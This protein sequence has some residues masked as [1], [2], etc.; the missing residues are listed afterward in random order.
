MREA[1]RIAAFRRLLVSYAGD[2]C[3]DW[4]VSIAAAVLVFAETNSAMATTALFLANR[5][6]PAVVVPPLA[7]RL[8]R[9]RPTRALTWL[10]GTDVLVLVALAYTATDFSLLAVCVLAFADGTLAATGRAI[11]RSATAT[12]MTREGLLREGNAVLN[13]SFGIM[14]VAAPAIAGALVAA[15]SAQAVFVIAAG[16][17][18]GLALLMGITEGPEGTSD[19]AGW[20]TRLRAGASSAL[21]NS[22]VRSV[23]VLEAAL[24]VLFAMATPIEIVLAKDTLGAGDAG[25]GLLLAS[26]GAGMVIGSVAFSRILRQS[27][28]R[29]LVIS[30]VMVGVA[31]VGMGLAPTLIVACAA[32]VFGGAGNG[33]QWVSVV[34]V[35]QEAVEDDMQTR[36]AGILEAVGTAMP[37]LGFLLGG[38]LASAFDPRV[39][40]VTSGVSI[41]LVILLFVAVHTVQRRETAPAET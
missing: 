11:T 19:E 34:I 25:Y 15:T 16:I 14:N 8:D 4:F 22:R 12:V 3:G 39:A 37:G 24:L 26:W 13:V 7:A 10:Y 5:F 28:I 29:L 6:A 41:G 27:M 17:F 33:M 21:A 1:L 9:L 35:V 32:A 2:E 31:Y 18:L 38:A 30:S 23:L 20:L 40:F 36:I